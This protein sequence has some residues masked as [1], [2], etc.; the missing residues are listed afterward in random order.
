[1]VERRASFNPTLA[2]ADRERLR[3]K[4]RKW[5]KAIRLYSCWCRC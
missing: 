5:Y 2:C 4:A 3:Q 1:V